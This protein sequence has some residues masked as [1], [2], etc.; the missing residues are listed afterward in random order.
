LAD[1]CGRFTREEHE[2]RIGASHFR[3]AGHPNFQNATRLRIHPRT[4]S[5][6]TEQI[7]DSHLRLLFN[8]SLRR[9]TRQSTNPLPI[10]RNCRSLPERISRG[11]T[12]AR[13]LRCRQ[14]KCLSSFR[15]QVQPSPL[16]RAND[17]PHLVAERRPKVA[18]PFKAGLLSSS[19][20]MHIGRFEQ[21]WPEVTENLDRAPDHAIRE[22]VFSGPMRRN[23]A[24]ENNRNDNRCHEDGP[25]LKGWANIGRRCATTGI[26]DLSEESRSTTLAGCRPRDLITLHEVDGKGKEDGGRYQ[27]S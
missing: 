20:S 25:A 27:R 8:T 22:L 17:G 4:P 23:E 26:G 7:G 3:F 1:E 18:Q 21:S 11:A 24:Q 6:S 9:H 14:A 12:E 5:G 16:T 15:L 13:G 19:H 2:R 10:R